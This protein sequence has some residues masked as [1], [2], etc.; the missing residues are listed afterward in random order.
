MT[1]RRRQIDRAPAIGNL[2]AR[3]LDRRAHPLLGFAH[4]AFGQTYR[5]E[6]RNSAADIDFDFDPKSVNP[7]DC[8]RQY[9]SQQTSSTRS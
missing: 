7:G 4:R 3:V 5:F 1:L 8:A 9:A 6:R 2:L